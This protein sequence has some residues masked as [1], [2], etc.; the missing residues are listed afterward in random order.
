MA[1][2]TVPRRQTDLLE[3]V[4]LTL[5]GKLTREGL[6]EGAI[7]PNRYRGLTLV[8]VAEVNKADEILNLFNRHAVD[9]FDFGPG[10]DVNVL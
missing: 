8:M 3:A 4:E 6:L 5:E 9:Q 2:A 1:V 7:T 10:T